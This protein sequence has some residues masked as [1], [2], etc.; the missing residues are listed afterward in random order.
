MECNWKEEENHRGRGKKELRAL[1]SDPSSNDSL[2][3]MQS[4]NEIDENK[5][6]ATNTEENAVAGPTT[7]RAWQDF[8]KTGNNSQPE[9]QSD[10]EE[11]RL[12]HQLKTSLAY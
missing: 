6:A 2:I 3:N 7:R 4:F 8:C 11:G 9:S 10:E 5:A 1:P 12:E